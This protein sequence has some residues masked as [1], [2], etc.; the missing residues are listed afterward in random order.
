MKNILFYKYV[1][2]ENPEKFKEEQFKLCRSLNLLGTI[3]VAKEGINCCLSGKEENLEQYKKTLI[4]NSKFSDIKF[5]EGGTNKHTFKKLHVRVR[6]EIVSSKFNVDI[7]NK[8]KYIE[9]K[10]L[11]KLFDHDE[12]LVLLDAR[13][14]YEYNIGKFKGAIH[15]DLDTFREFPTKIKQLQN[16]K[17]NESLKNKKI[18]TYCTGGVRCE[19]VSAFLRENG[20]KNVYQLHGGIL[21]Y[22][23]DCGNDHWEGKCFVF[24]TRGAVDIDPNSQSEPITQC[25]LCNL[26]N[27][28]L[29]NCALTSCDRFF[30]ACENC[31]EVLEGCCSK[32]C[33][34]ELSKITLKIS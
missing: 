9:P 1:D 29:H 30:T 32:R 27:A 23:K 33:R 12:D 16:L 26:P 28:N 31:L 18:I 4:K 10:Q 25:V 7:K 11:K 24:D 21:T 34:G 15:L 2:I 3:L 22:G 8:G 13:N 17:N 6:D 5:K 20:F 14:N 19:K